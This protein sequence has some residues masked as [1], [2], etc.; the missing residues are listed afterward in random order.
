M[1][2]DNSINLQ[3]EFVGTLHS[4]AL[5]AVVRSGVERLRRMYSRISSCRVV[6]DATPCRRDASRF[7]T[8]VE[9][10][11]PGGEQLLARSHTH[12]RAAPDAYGSVRE[13]FRVMRCEL[14]RFR[15][16]RRAAERAAGSP[17]SP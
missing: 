8:R 6:I 10:H 11:L 4:D 7:E 16:R 15:G 9:V 17:T 1:N 2:F 5:E 3:I 14:G 13:A 12:G